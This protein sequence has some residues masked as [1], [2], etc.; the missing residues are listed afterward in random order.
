LSITNHFRYRVKAIGLRDTQ[1][2]VMVMATS[3][4]GSQRRQ[5]P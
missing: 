4:Q 5:K 3:G 1:G 2:A